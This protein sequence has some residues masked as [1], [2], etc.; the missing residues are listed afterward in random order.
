MLPWT[1]LVLSVSER[2]HQKDLRGCK[3]ELSFSNKSVL[4]FEKK[5]TQ[6]SPVMQ[7]DAIKEPEISSGDNEGQNVLNLTEGENHYFKCHN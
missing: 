1:L 7:K 3:L 6:N 2:V 5:S 4:E